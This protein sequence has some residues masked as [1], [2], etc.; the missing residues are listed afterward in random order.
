[1]FCKHCGLQISDDSAFCQKCGEKQTDTFD[2]SMVDNSES[3]ETDKIEV[4][5]MLYVIKPDTKLPPVGYKVKVTAK[6]NVKGKEYIAAIGPYK[7]DGTPVPKVRKMYGLDIACFS[8]NP[9]SQE[10]IQRGN[11]KRS[12][13]RGGLVAL[14]CLPLVIIIGVIIYG[15]LSGGGGSSASINGAWVHNAD[16]LGTSYLVT[17]E[18]S[19]NGNYIMYYNLPTIASN[20]TRQG[21]YTRS[22][23]TITMKY[24]YDSIATYTYNPSSNTI[25]DYHGNVFRRR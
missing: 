25:S 7:A 17:I 16:L 23:N 20:I 21:T 19:G 15:V 11:A 14:A 12:K 3:P 4:G 6:H 1:M 2:T 5:S 22:G 18:F 8:T 10:I 13:Q 9:P 24:G